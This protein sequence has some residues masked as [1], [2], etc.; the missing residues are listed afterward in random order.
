MAGT[1]LY[2]I[3]EVPEAQRISILCTVW[4]PSWCHQDFNPFEMNLE[5]SHVYSA[6]LCG[7]VLSRFT[8]V[9]LFATL[10]TVACQAPLSMGFS[11]Q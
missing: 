10:W 8:H 7:T 3:H 11:R 2:F 6:M 9:R 5:V 4:S 1:F